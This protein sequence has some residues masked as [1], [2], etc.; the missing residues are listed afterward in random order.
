MSRQYPKDGNGR[1]FDTG[2]LSYLEL[3]EAWHSFNKD[4]A[5]SAPKLHGWRK[6][7]AALGLSMLKGT[8]PLS[9][10]EKL[11]VLF[12]LIWA[13]NDEYT[14]TK[15]KQVPLEE[16]IFIQGIIDQLLEF[17]QVDALLKAEL[18]RETGRFEESMSI[19]NGY[20]TDKEFI[21]KLIKRLKEENQAQNT[22]PFI[23]SDRT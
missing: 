13:F 12:M 22:T 8:R 16:Q 15:V 14:R 19:I 10:K 2:D 23:I 5:S 1:S 18:L 9:D 3:K 11:S 17:D 21:Q 20:S 7:K 6:L 4:E